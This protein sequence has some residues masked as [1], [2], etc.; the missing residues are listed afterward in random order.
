VVLAAARR[1]PILGMDR[2]V[3]ARDLG[4]AAVRAAIQELGLRDL[5]KIGALVG[6][7]VAQ[8]AFTRNIAK[9][10]ARGAGLPHSIPCI[11]LDRQCSSS[12]DAAGVAYNLIA[13]GVEQLVIAIGVESMGDTSYQVSPQARYS[14][15]NVWL[16]S[17]ARKPWGRWLQLF[18]FDKA[19]GPGILFGHYAESGLAT[20]ENFLDPQAGNMPKT[21][22]IVSN[23]CGITRQHA[24]RLADL[25]HRR[26]AAAREVLA[27]DIVPV[28]VPGAG[29]IDEDENVRPDSDASGL[30]P[31]PDTGGLITAGNASQMGA[32]GVALILTTPEMAKELGATILAEFVD[33]QAAGF[34]ANAMGLGPVPAVEQLLARHSLTV[35]GIQRPLTVDDIDYFEI[36]EAFAGIWAALMKVLGISED[37]CN[38]YGGGVSIGHPL[39]ATG[40]RLIAL[41]ARL[42]HDDHL[43]LAMALQCAAGGMGTAV[44]MQ[45]FVEEPTLEL[46]GNQDDR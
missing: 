22:Q 21:A 14:P 4:V 35:D 12:M 8:D 19:Y 2:R 15:F 34:D 18:G 38:L 36:N 32:C 5:S 9:H 16:R 23:L 28:F 46:E 30:K 37:R 1:T 31:R 17:A 39:G 41:I 40:A 42:I 20:L 27:R 29:I 45:R 43:D 25:S 7:Q 6:G 24:D 11:S 26:A 33:F 3:S 10:V 13:S 44:L